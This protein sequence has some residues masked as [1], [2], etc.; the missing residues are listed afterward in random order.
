MDVTSETNLSSR[1]LS[2]E[3]N[4]RLVEELNEE[5]R[6][7]LLPVTTFVGIETVLGFCGNL[8]ILYVF[9]FHYHRCNFKYFVLC[10]S[11]VDITSTLTTMPG[12]IVTHTYWYI[13]PS[14]LLCKIK[15][16]FNVF[17]VCGSMYGLFVISIDRFRKICRPFG[18]QIKP[19]VAV[20]L[21]SVQLLISFIMA[22]PVAF[23]WGT[24]SAVTVFKGHNIT[25]TVCELDENFKATSIP[26][27][28]TI[29][30]ETINSIIMFAMVVIYIF[31]GRKLFMVKS[32][33][34]GRFS[35]PG[36]TSI[37]SDA[38]SALT[39]GEHIASVK[40]SNKRPKLATERPVTEQ[41]EIDKQSEQNNAKQCQYMRQ[42]NSKKNAS[43]ISTVSRSG[44]VLAVT[45]TE[46]SE[47]S[48]PITRV[49]R[50]ENKSAITQTGAKC[51][52]PLTLAEGSENTLPIT[53]VEGSENT[54]PITRAEAR[55]SNL[56]ITWAMDLLNRRATTL[57]IKQAVES[58]ISSK[59]SGAKEKENTLPITQVG[60]SDSTRRPVRNRIGKK[61]K[62]KT[63]IMFILTAVFIFTTILYM[64]LLSLIAHD[65]LETL[66]NSGKAAY[67]FFFRFYF[68]NHVINPILYGFLDPHFKKVLKETLRACLR[69]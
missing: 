29:V 7:T 16:F 4:Q 47:N 14:P 33:S 62:R 54:L 18:W 55:R 50:S 57:P 51:S 39:S 2:L 41:L 43:P 56:P 67:F 21:C 59:M 15:S 37:G 28:Y 26:L 19:G 20:I 27:R 45:R 38:S 8:L 52:L 53:L 1:P 10:L 31:V 6:S 63:L 60:N 65:V 46:E 3:E 48:S 40:D 69:N 5:L 11:F 35:P 13:Y 32:N 36:N 22:L 49:E 58:G 66:S 42:I 23:F 44:M 61:I 30:L 24:H 9:V 34:K 12:E 17:T 68:I 64:T 25:I